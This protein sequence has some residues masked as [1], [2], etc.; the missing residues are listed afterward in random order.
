MRWGDE[1]ARP[2]V[3]GRRVRMARRAG[4]MEKLQQQFN[5]MLASCRDPCVTEFPPAPLVTISLT[6]A[7]AT[8]GTAIRVLACP[9]T[10]V[11]SCLPVP[12]T[13]AA[14]VFASVTGTRLAVL[15]AVSAANPMVE[16]KIPVLTALLLPG[17]GWQAALFAV[18]WRS[19]VTPTAGARAQTQAWLG[20]E[21]NSLLYCVRY[22]RD[23]W[24]VRM[25][26]LSLPDDNPRETL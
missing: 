6:A 10:H 2:W 19:L 5:C 12:M 14:A 3:V 24:P 21:Y 26:P 22:K 1:G 8:K 4:A 13:P 7:A 17:L 11:Y 9:M 25:K 18:H 20:C 15:S 23:A 16:V